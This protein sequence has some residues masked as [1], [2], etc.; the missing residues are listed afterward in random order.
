MGVLA[1]I[2]VSVLIIEMTVEVSKSV[3][4]IF[5]ITDRII[6]IVFCIDYFGRFLISKD[7]KKFVKSNV[8]DLLSIIPFNSLFKA[9]RIIKITKMTKLARLSKVT[10]TT[11]ILKA[12][13]LV[14]KFKVKVD[15]FLK[16]NNFNYVLYMTGITVILGAIGI[17]LVEKMSLSNA[18]WWSFVTTT[19][20]GYGDISPTTILGRII[21]VVLMLVGIGF[22]GM[23]TGTIA[24]F[25]IKQEENPSY[26]K[27]VV[28]RI[29]NRLD[30][31]DLL[32]KEELD[33][34][35]KVLNPLRIKN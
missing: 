11:K 17:S 33:E 23:L 3:L 35:F 14:A 7:K 13:V 6:W 12:T 20:V 15:K 28:Q 1:I 25:F 2:V 5:Y 9:L 27:S 24:T 32:S 10:K 29:K 16:T 18:L 8:I 30:D 19:T 31:F 21:A 26:K 22:I 4:K 34:M